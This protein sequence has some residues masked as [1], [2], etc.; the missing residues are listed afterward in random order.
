MNIK[1][2]A[3]TAVFFTYENAVKNKKIGNITENCLQKWQ[4][5]GIIEIR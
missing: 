1:T 3:R 2:A 4:K 5:K